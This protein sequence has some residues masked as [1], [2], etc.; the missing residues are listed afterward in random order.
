MRRLPLLLLLA[1]ACGGS[2]GIGNTCSDT[3]A[4]VTGQSCLT[5]AQGGYC[6]ILGCAAPGVQGNCPSDSVCDQIFTQQ[7]ACVKRCNVQA[8]C[9]ATT[10]CNGITGSNVKACKPKQS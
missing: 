8:D 9:P 4:C 5:Q 10:D 2:S 3:Q 1:A 7:N 6:T